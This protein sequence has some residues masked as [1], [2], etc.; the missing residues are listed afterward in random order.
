MPNVLAPFGLEPY[1]MIGGQPYNGQV[2]TFPHTVNNATAIFQGNC[3]NLASGQVISIGA[4]PTT[5]ANANTPVGVFVGCSY[6]EPNTNTRVWRNQLPANAI[7][8][9][10]TGI[11]L[12]VADDPDMLFKIQASGVVTNAAIGLNCTL[13]NFGGSTVTGRSSVRL[14]AGGIAAGNTLA[15][16]IVDVL[17]PATLFPHVI[18]KWNQGVHAYQNPTGQ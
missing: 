7:N 15:V 4:T 17:D 9:G 5:T 8:L 1:Q 16:R 6:N 18:V 13:D 12:Y 14:A 11:E 2:R 10:I 3:V